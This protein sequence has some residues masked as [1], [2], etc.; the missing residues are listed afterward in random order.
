MVSTTHVK[1]YLNIEHDRV[2][3]LAS[4]V[5]DLKQSWRMTNASGKLIS[6]I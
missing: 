3:E 5:C 6:E 1:P 2:S 4:K